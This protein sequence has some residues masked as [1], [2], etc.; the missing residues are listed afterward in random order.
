MVAAEGTQSTPE[1]PWQGAHQGQRRDRQHNSTSGKRPQWQ[2][3][4]QDSGAAQDNQ[5]QAREG[6]TKARSNAIIARV[7][8]TWGMNAL[9]PGMS[10][11]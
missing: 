9:A 3:N 7:G 11:L 8:S 2:C 1:V 5:P 4:T 6:V 10:D